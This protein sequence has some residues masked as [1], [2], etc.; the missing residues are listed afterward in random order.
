MK[1]VYSQPNSQGIQTPKEKT[2]NKIRMTLTSLVAAFILLL[3]AW[4]QA[5]AL[6]VTPEVEADLST[7]AV[8][9]GTVVGWTSN[10]YGES[11]IPTGLNNVIAL[12]GCLDHSLA[13][14]S[15]GTVVEPH[16]RDFTPR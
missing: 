16:H 11:T 10:L 5:P 1:D 7:Q 9:P 6:Q 8:T 13:L 2:M 14:K 15:D 4:S 3:A 12:A